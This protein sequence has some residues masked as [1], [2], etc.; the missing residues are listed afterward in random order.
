MEELA[1]QENLAVRNHWR[2]GPF[3]QPDTERE[4][5]S[6]IPESWYGPE[7]KPR[8]KSAK[9]RAEEVRAADR[10]AFFALIKRLVR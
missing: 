2:A 8:G 10:A 4:I 7:K 1:R 3:D 5:M 6:R 9:R